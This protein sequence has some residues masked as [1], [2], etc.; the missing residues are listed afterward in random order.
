M[1]PYMMDPLRMCREMNEAYYH[2]RRAYMI[3]RRIMRY[4]NPYRYMES[5]PGMYDEG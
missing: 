4:Q 3:M 2:C 5:S 1:D